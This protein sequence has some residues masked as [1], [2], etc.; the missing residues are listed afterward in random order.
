MLQRL[1][2]ALENLPSHSQLWP[3]SDSIFGLLSRASRDSTTALSLKVTRDVAVHGIP[4]VF[5]KTQSISLALA[6][7]YKVRWL[8]WDYYDIGERPFITV[9]KIMLE[10]W[11]EQEGVEG[12]TEEKLEKWKEL[13]RYALR[14][15]RV[16][17]ADLNG[18][19]PTW[20][21]SAART[22]PSRTNRLLSVF[23]ID[24]VCGLAF[25]FAS[26]SHYPYT[27]VWQAMEV[28]NQTSS[29]LRL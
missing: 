14:W 23:G 27:R 13:R 3:D 22:G 2:E 29:R 5:R 21:P 7:A 8:D 11:S 24:W 15:Y 25:H 9:D 10:I 12:H 28:L 19:L 18:P 6:L 17:L 1:F 4:T 16:D 20:N 26:C